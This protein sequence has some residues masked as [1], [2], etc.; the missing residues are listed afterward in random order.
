MGTTNTKKSTKGSVS[1]DR[2]PRNGSG[3]NVAEIELSVTDETGDRD[4]DTNEHLGDKLTH[5]Y[6]YLGRC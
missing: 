5:S 4:V 1:I 6:L 3:L 2:T